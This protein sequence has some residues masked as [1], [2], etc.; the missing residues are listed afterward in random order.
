MQLNNDM[1]YSTF[2]HSGIVNP[3]TT[4][5]PENKEPETVVI[6]YD[7]LSE[8]LQSVHGRKEIKTILE[9]IKELKDTGV[10][11]KKS[12]AEAFELTISEDD[13]ALKDIKKLAGL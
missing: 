7:L 4:V 5:L 3:K 8:I 13:K 9:K 6:E 11:T 12:H 2:I 10:L 1:T